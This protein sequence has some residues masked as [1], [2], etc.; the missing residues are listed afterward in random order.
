M[1][2]SMWGFPLSPGIGSN[3][4]LL[5][6]WCH[7]TVLLS[8]ISFSSCPQS[9]PASGSFLMCWLFAS[10]G[11]SIGARGFSFSISP[12]N[13]YSMLT[14]FGRISLQSKGLSKVFSSITFQR[15]KFFST[16]AFFMV[17]LSHPYMTTRKNITL[18]RGTLVG[19]VMSL[20]LNALS[21]FIIAFLPSIF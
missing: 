21:R 13:D 8:V 15:H 16:Q 3:S 1:N 17:H 4:C 19:K 7:P 12:S 14:F 6:W 9:F 20:L 2:C 10:G 5:S 11:Q 18:S